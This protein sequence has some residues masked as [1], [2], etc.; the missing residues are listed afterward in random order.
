MPTPNEEERA[1]MVEDA[2]RDSSLRPTP[3]SDEERLLAKLAEVNLAARNTIS[4]ELVKH[5]LAKDREKVQQAV[6]HT[7]FQQLETFD[8]HELANLLAAFLTSHLLSSY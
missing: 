5:P 3:L 7:Y 1:R 4:V 2:F 8:K 6:Q